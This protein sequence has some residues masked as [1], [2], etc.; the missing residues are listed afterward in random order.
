MSQI[1]EAFQSTQ[2]Q[3]SE[4]VVNGNTEENEVRTYTRQE[5][6]INNLKERASSDTTIFRGTLM[7]TNLCFGVTIFTFAIRATYFGLVWLI[8]TG[9]IVGIITYWSIMCG[10]IAS[11]KSKEDD[12]SE[13]TEKILG[14]KTR[15]FLNVIIIIYSYAVMMMF[16]ALT[17]SLFGRFI[18]AAGFTKKYPEYDGFDEEIWTK[19]YIKFPVYIGLTLG[20]CFMCLIKDMDKLNFSAYIGVFAVIYSLIVVLIQCHDYYKY[21]KNK[22]YIKDDKSTHIN[23]INLGKAFSKKLEFFKGV[24]ALFTANAC[25]TGVFPVFVGFKYQKDGLKK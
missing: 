16:M 6:A 12:Y 23:W 9:A 3:T 21:S 1:N 20:L 10:I 18:H 11:S 17:Y 2:H 13:L 7:I 22:Y 8:V 5:E 15:H 24:A 19:A 14:R 25:H 4:E